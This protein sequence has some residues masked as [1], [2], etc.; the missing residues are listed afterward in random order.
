MPS[1]MCF[2]ICCAKKCNHMAAEQDFVRKTVSLPLDVYEKGARM[3]EVRGFKH[4]FSA[5]LAQLIREA[6]E[7]AAMIDDSP[8][9]YRVVK[10]T[11]RD[12]VEALADKS[13]KA[14]D[15]KKK[16]AARTH[17]A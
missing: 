2:R 13:Q 6:D 9:K 11:K 14:L 5:Y 8:A 4:S 1:A 16:K 3:A 10:K 12:V 15:A 17:A 7:S